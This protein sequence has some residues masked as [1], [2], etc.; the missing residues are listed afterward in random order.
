MNEIVCVAIVSESIVVNQSLLSHAFPTSCN[1]IFSIYRSTIPPRLA[2]LASSSRQGFLLLGA[3]FGSQ[4]IFSHLAFLASHV[5]AHLGAAWS[6][7][8]AWEPAVLLREASLC[9]S[10]HI[11]LSGR[12]IELLLLAWQGIV[13][14]HVHG[15]WRVCHL[16]VLLLVAGELVWV[17]H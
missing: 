2:T 6:F 12:V 7:I 5:F 15:L 3:L 10:T 17:Y 8:T 1:Q 16:A 4:L 14:T 9:A 11:L 13:L